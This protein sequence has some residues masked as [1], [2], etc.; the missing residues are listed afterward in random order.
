[1]NARPVLAVTFVFTGML[2]GSLPDATTPPF[3]VHGGTPEQHQR[4]ADAAA[5]YAGA[6]LDLPP[7][8]IRFYHTDSECRGA[9]GYFNTG[10]DPWL[11]SICT[12]AL[13]WVYEH[14][15]AHAWERANVSHELREAFL[16]LRGL[17]AWNDRSLPWNE[18]G[19][20]WAAVV[21]QQGLTG[22]PLPPDLSAE[23]RSRLRGFEILTGQPAPI[24]IAWLEAKNVPCAE[25]P[26]P[27]SRQLTD[28]GGLSCRPSAS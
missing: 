7:L 15:L 21:I 23:T 27:L 13:G 22:L 18:R 17:E 12:P 9:P 1:M 4:L 5:V 25:R 24:L 11:I 6:G 8:E 10:T 2:S 19:P 28:V 20:E 26:T 14:E 3:S 16:E